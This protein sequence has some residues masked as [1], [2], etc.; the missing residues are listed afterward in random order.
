M[1]ETLT[2]VRTQVAYIHAHPLFSL[3]IGVV[4]VAL[5]GWIW[6]QRDA[7]RA[8]PVRAVHRNLIVMIS[9]GLAVSSGFIQNRGEYLTL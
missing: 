5:A 2:S 4:L 3:G 9:V 6:W 7:I 1:M 8:A